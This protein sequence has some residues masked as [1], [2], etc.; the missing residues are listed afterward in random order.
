MK[1]SLPHFS[2]STPLADPDLA[3]S[4]SASPNLDLCDWTEGTFMKI[5]H[6]TAFSMLVV[7]KMAYE[8]S[9]R[10][11]SASSDREQSRASDGSPILGSSETGTLTLATPDVVPNSCKHCQRLIFVFENSAT[12]AHQFDFTYLDIAR[13]A[14]GDCLLCQWNLSDPNITLNLGMSWKKVFEQHSKIGMSSN[15]RLHS[16]SKSRFLGILDNIRFGIWSASG[17]SKLS[18]SSTLKCYTKS[19]E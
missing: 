14:S 1:C 16:W 11:G 13:A 15:L 19:G 18:Y 5:L 3:L 2:T 10:G 12:A 17:S 9:S 7:C 8:N 6:L 4:Y